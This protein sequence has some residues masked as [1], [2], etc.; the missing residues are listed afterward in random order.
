[1]ISAWFTGTSD[2]E[3][4]WNTYLDKLEEICL[5]DWLELNQKGWG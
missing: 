5:S 3:A 1:M 4:D 2:V